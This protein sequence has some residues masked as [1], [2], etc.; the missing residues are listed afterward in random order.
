MGLSLALLGPAHADWQARASADFANLAPYRLIL[1]GEQHDAAQH[2]TLQ[3]EL[4]S[5]LTARQGLA[6]LVL[7]MADQGHSTAGLDPS[8]TETKVQTALGWSESGWPWADYGPTIMAA[9]RAGVPVLGANLPRPAMRAAMQNT[10]LEASLSPE[11]LKTQDERMRSGHCGMLP[12]SQIRPMTRIQIARDQ[13]MAQ[14]MAKALAPTGAVL[15]L[16]GNGHVERHLGV[17]VHLGTLAAQA[18]VI[19]MQAGSANTLGSQA[20]LVWPTPALTPKDYCAG[21]STGR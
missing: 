16:A 21:L 12:E 14:S 11:A 3:T 7:E 1:L 17:P 13:A 19:T 6:A 5:W 8:A 20:D 4:V 18:R 15:L 2:H 9:V 10:A